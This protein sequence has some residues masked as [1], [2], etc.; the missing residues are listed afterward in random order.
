MANDFFQCAEPAIMHVG[1]G[2]GDVSQGRSFKFRSIGFSLGD[3]TATAI[4]SY[5]FQVEPIVVKSKITE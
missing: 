1:T 4:G 2:Q 5:R 3:G